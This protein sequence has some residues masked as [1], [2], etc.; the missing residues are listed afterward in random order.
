MNDVF[1][2]SLPSPISAVLELRS[3]GG[4]AVVSAGRATDAQRA[5]Y[6]R[7]ALEEKLIA[8]LRGNR[9]RELVI[10]TGSAGGG[11]SATIDLLLREGIVES[12]NVIE[13]ATHA[14]TPRDDQVDRLAA[15]FAPFADGNSAPA[16]VPTR[17]IA[18]NSGM[19]IRFF[20][21][22]RGRGFTALERVF[23]VRIGLETPGTP[24]ALDQRV[25]VLNLDERPTT[26]GADALFE[27]MLEA[28]DPTRPGGV[29]R[30]AARCATCAVRRY[31]FVRTNAV[32]VSAPAARAA[33]DGL[34]HGLALRRGRDLAPRA[35]WDL[36]TDLIT[37][38]EP[39]TQSDP[40]DRIAELAA[41][42]D[43][44]TVWRRLACNGAFA[45]NTI[46]EVSRLG[47]LARD[48]RVHDPSLTAQRDSH[49]I[50]ASAGIQP[51][52]DGARL[53]G[54]LGRAEAEAVA[55]AA[56]ALR[57]AGV[58]PAPGRGLVRAAFLAG[59]LQRKDDGDLF[60]QALAEYATYRADGGSYPALTQLRD[61]VAQ[62]LVR[63]F[64]AVAR[65][66]DFLPADTR[67]TAREVRLFVQADLHSLD[68]LDVPPDPIFRADAEGAE[69][70]SYRPL[71]VVLH[72][73]GTHQILVTLPLFRLLASLARGVAHSG[74][75]IERF[76][77]LRRAVERA[78]RPS[79]GGALLISLGDGTRFK[80]SRR[81]ILGGQKP[82]PVLEEVS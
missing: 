62:G 45:G 24:S 78:A 54:W 5:I 79:A 57:H 14:D 16:R 75:E 31:C 27:R 59:S 77:A 81:R 47:D 42:D 18:L 46:G 43:S 67:S 17:L 70:L 35:L 64:G 41:A 38:G 15:F 32:I 3:S 19:A 36:A 33:I 74:S 51:E 40:C 80:L 76:E 63:G 20:D 12:E 44:D 4:G 61:L 65:G 28:F 21:R 13:D 82:R 1:D 71:R 52:E 49:E 30:G 6:V 68:V 7:S 25:L 34:A 8:H 53:S 72:V 11:K 66:E 26:G 9:P 37:G 22:A 55:T 48:V 23:K 69:I 58:W 73:R 56:G 10:I 50:L 60:A 39:F 29:M 2:R